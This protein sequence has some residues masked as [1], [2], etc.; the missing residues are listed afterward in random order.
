MPG[1]RVCESR[2]RQNKYSNVVPVPAPLFSRHHSR[3]RMAGTAIRPVAKGGRTK[4]VM[5]ESTN[6]A[7]RAS[8]VRS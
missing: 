4:C 7:S 1:V 2:Q 8:D 6:V 5:T 3:L